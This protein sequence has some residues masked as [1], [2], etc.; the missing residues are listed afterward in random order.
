MF[1]LR[2]S[3]PDGR[4]SQLDVVG[5]R[6]SC[7]SEHKPSRPFDSGSAPTFGQK[8]ILRIQP[9][10]TSRVL[11]HQSFR[12]NSQFPKLDCSPKG[13]RLVP[14]LSSF[15]KGNLEK[16]LRSRSFDVLRF[17]Q[18]SGSNFLKTGPHPKRAD[19]F[20]LLVE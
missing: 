11:S 19:Y 20:Y 14:D 18:L 15:D 17:K 5:S 6:E 8:K 2:Q 1:I 4:S 9:A 16:G 12:D 7:T 13:A 10:G 3:Q